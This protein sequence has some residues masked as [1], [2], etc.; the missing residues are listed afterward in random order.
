MLQTGHSAGFPRGVNEASAELE[1]NGGEA[2]GIMVEPTLLLHY[3]LKRYWKV[4]RIKNSVL[5]DGASLD[6]PALWH[7]PDGQ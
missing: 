7:K 1:S 3:P 6:N 4:F 5:P 2:S